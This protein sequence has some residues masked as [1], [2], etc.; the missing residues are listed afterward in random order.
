MITKLYNSVVLWC[1]IIIFLVSGLLLSR[2]YYHKVN[3]P[4]K[5]DMKSK[6]SM[7]KVKQYRGDYKSVYELF[8]AIEKNR[9]IF[10]TN[11]LTQLHMKYNFQCHMLYHWALIKGSMNISIPHNSKFMVMVYVKDNTVHVFQFSRPV[12]TNDKNLSFS[13]ESFPCIV[14]AFNQINHFS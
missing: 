4:R 1:Y 2:L 9:V 11:F 6:L 7:R 3:K 10:D 8:V 14:L 5:N 13:F 12:H